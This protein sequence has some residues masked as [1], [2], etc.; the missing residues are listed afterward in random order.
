[1]ELEDEKENEKEA[2]LSRKTDN[3]LR[4]MSRSRSVGAKK[5]LTSDEERMQR[6]RK[7]LQ[8]EWKNKGMSSDADRRIPVKMP[9]HL[10]CGIRGN[11]KTD[12][13]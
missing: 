6:M 1:M 10:Y 2:R 3:K 8:R 11:G 5:V 9:K 4:S 12:R 13:R 7:K